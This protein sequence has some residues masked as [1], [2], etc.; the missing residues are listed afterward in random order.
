MLFRKKLNISERELL[1]GQHYKQPIWETI[2]APWWGFGLKLFV[3]W[4]LSFFI[5]VV[6][7]LEE[8]SIYVSY[9]FVEIVS[10]NLFIKGPA[11]P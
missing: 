3:A 10:Y 7:V 6:P 2:F 8:I 4:L 9:L 1:D 11:R 5:E